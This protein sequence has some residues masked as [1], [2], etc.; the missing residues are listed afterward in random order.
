MLTLGSVFQRGQ[1]TSERAFGREMNASVESMSTPEV[2]T[3]ADIPQSLYSFE[4]RTA[5]VQRILRYETNQGILLVPA[6]ELVRYLF[7]HNRTLANALMRPNALEHLYV[8][9]QPG[10]RDSLSLRFTREMP[11]R[12]LSHRFVK[13]F[14][15]LAVDPV[16]RRSWDSVLK[17][18]AGQPYVLLSPPD[19]GAS[20]WCFRGVGDGKCTL[21]LEILHLSGRQLPA[22]AIEYSHPALSKI[23]RVPPRPGDEGPR[24]RGKEKEVGGSK[25]Q[26]ERTYQLEDSAGTSQSNA[27]LKSLVG[28]EKA[29]DFENDAAV[30]AKRETVERPR[31]KKRGGE[32]GEGSSGPKR[33]E[34]VKVSAGEHAGG[35]PL[36]PIEFKLLTPAPLSAKGKVSGRRTYARP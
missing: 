26:I 35:A 8:P 15:W 13:E 33:K 7:G 22:R 2:V 5:G 16:G 3:S 28:N 36:P 17:L 25:P 18:S 14:A 12:C 10:W 34:T 21:V 11:A 20:Q 27:S 29:L 23:L 6:V 31:G 19:V 24:G 32:A 9:Q 4:G 1:L 30:T